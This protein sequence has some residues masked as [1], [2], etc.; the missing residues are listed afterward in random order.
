[1]GEEGLRCASVDSIPG[2]NEAWTFDK[3]L[4]FFFS[5]FLFFIKEN[6][7]ELFLGAG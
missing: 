1:M 5:F 2:C 6:V 4:E 3:I 7:E